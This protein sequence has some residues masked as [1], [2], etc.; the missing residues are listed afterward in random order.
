MPK[1]PTVRG[2][3]TVV[4]ADPAWQY[5]NKKTRSAAAKNYRV[6][7]VFEM[8]TLPVG[9]RAARDA[10]LF[11]WT[12]G[13]MQKRAIALGE[14]WGFTYK[15]IGFCWAKR[16]RKA[17]TPFFGMGN[18]SRAKFELVLIFTRGSP[19][20]KD[21]S[22]P[23]FLWS[24]IRRHSEKPAEIR[25]R[26]ERLGGDVPRIELFSRHVVPGWKRCGNEVLS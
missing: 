23:Q 9:S 1:L 10:F 13:P 19:K 4:Y 7:S 22:V 11:M 6:M 2:G 24:P 12:T 20:V 25:K 8:Q 18:Y 3:F 5:S 17:N 26:I 21:H 15:T 14:A 16:N